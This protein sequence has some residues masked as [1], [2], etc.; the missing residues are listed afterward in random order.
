MATGLFLGLTTVDILNYVSH[1][2]S[3]NEKLRADQQLIFAGGPAANAAVAYSAFSGDVSL[4]T[5]LGKQPLATLAVADLLRN[6]IKIVDLTDDDCKLPV[7]SAITVDT[8]TG[9]RSVV[10]TNTTNR[11]LVWPGEPAD[12][13]AYVSVLMLDGYYLKHACDLAELAQRNNIPVILDGGSW[14]EGLDRLLPHV[15]YAICSENFIPPGCDGK[16]S[17]A[18][19]L[20]NAGVGNVCISRGAQKMLAWSKGQYEEVSVEPVEVAD[21]LGAGDIL[22]GAFCHFIQKNDFFTS[23][24]LASVVATCSCKY[25]G[26]RKWI[27]HYRNTDR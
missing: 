24:K 5:G 9:D 6:N 17:V 26:T 3:S 11:G 15:D 20:S 4:I 23:L 1:Y 13:L 10:Y 7:L 21:T 12:H 2:P 18:D 16:R 27:E 22:H 14:K 25:R 19:F 8:S